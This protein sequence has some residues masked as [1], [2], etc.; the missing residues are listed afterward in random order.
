MKKQA[1]LIILHKYSKS[2]RN[3]FS[4]LDEA[5]GDIYVHIDKKCQDS[6]LT[7]LISCFPN[8]IIINKRYDV[9]WGGFRMVQVMLSL[10]SEAYAQNKEYSH[11]VFLSG[12]DFPVFSGNDLQKY[13][14]EKDGLQLIRAYSITSSGCEHCNSKINRE[15]FFD[16]ITKNTT[17]SIILRSILSEI[18]IN[19]RKKNYLLYKQKVQEIYYGSQW[20]AITPACVQYILNQVDLNIYI[21]YFKHTFAPDEMF[22]HTIIFNSKFKYSN[23]MHGPEPYKNIWNL[24]NYT[25]LNSQILNCDIPLESSIIHNKIHN[26]FKKLKN[27]N[28]IKNKNLKRIGGSV[29]VLTMYDYNN[30]ISSGMPFCRKVDDIISYKLIEKMNGCN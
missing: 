10:L 21:N 16:G 17:L 5:D 4:V 22:F 3:L 2:L 30:I 6:R 28:N 20:F 23:M 14:N 15:F 9:A 13:F 11:Y 26:F 24:F 12:S 19:K 8:I 7:T 25:Y 1:F 29:D 27:E 18:M